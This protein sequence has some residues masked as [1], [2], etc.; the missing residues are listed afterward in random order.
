MDKMLLRIFQRE[1]ERQTCFA[2]MAFSDLE[3]A[4]RIGDI[5]RIWYSV[6]GFLVAVGNVSK[7]LWPSQPLAGC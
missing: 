7:L 5:D 1:V 4:L 3:A 6:Q 2:L